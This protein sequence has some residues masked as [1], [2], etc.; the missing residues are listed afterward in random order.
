MAF[1]FFQIPTDAS[2]E[3][4]APLNVFLRAHRVVRVTRQW[5]EAGKE[6]SWAFCV[7]YL[8]G[9]AASGPFSAAT[10]KV[11]YKELLP[12]EQFEVFARLRTLRRD[13]ESGAVDEATVQAKATALTAFTEHAEC[14]AWS[15]RVVSS[16]AAP[17]RRIR[18]ASQACRVGA[19]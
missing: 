17:T 3:L 7:E 11:D 5:C 16:I 9:P 13:W 1:A 2:T 14:L 10:A 4:A 8:D 18:A 6:S 12:P 19:S 15:R